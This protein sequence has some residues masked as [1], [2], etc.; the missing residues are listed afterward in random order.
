[1][2]RGSDA[3]RS[4]ND[5]VTVDVQVVVNVDVVVKVGIAGDIESVVYLERAGESAAEGVECTGRL[6]RTRNEKTIAAE[7][8]TGIGAM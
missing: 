1:M 4:I 2:Q 5:H 8:F 3:G 7:A 6:K